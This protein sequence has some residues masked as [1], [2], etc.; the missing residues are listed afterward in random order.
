M[1]L[2]IQLTLASRFT[3]FYIVTS[4]LV[5][6]WFYCSISTFIE[7]LKSFRMQQIMVSLLRALRV[8]NFAWIDWR[9]QKYDAQSWASFD[10]YWGF[11]LYLFQILLIKAQ[12]F[13]KSFQKKVFNFYNMIQV[14]LLCRRLCRAHLNLII[15]QKNKG[16]NGVQF[17]PVMLDVSKKSSHY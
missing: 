7:S 12:E 17:I 14:A 4:K 5:E 16:A 13:L 9:Y 2:D 6:A 1:A 3:E 8:L 11:L 15:P 10:W